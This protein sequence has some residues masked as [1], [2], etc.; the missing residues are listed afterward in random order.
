MEPKNIDEMFKRLN[1][2]IADIQK[3]NKKYKE[4]NK[5]EPVNNANEAYDRAMKGL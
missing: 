4:K 1:D 2:L 5:K 3:K